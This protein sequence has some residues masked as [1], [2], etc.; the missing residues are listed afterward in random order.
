[1]EGGTFTYTPRDGK[2]GRDTF[3]Y[4][5]ADEVGNVSK[6]ATVTITIKKRQTQ[7]SYSDLEG[8]SCAYAAAYLAE[9]G[10][11]TGEQ[12][13]GSWLFRPDETVTRGEFLSMCMVITGSKAAGGITRTGFADDSDIPAW[14]KPWVAAAVMGKVISGA[15]TDSGTLV[16]SPNRPINRAEAAVMLNNAI[17]VTDVTGTEEEAWPV[18]ASQAAANLSSVRVMNTGLGYE[19]QITRAEAAEMLMKAAE[20][21]AARSAKRSLL[22][23]AK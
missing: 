22:S 8:R 21:I 20:L 14:Q 15:R 12:V 5:A 13:G 9:A 11:F 2:T 6:E 7:V 1:M 19:G 4:A 10:V 23:W 17:G 18:W 16:F 3:K